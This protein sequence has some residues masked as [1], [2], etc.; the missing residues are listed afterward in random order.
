MPIT[1]EDLE[2]KNF[3]IN[4]KG[5]ELDSKPLRL[6][7]ALMAA[8]L[9]NIFQNPDK[10][11]KEQIKQAET[12]LDELI[13]ELIPEL[14]NKKLGMST[15]LELLTQLMEHIEPADN[16]ELREKNVKFDTDPKV[17]RTG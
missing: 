17:P 1:I 3:K 8:K 12:D 5:L 7:H 11:T 9:G 6:S 2:P 4:L 13:G 16:K 10:V 14:S 15:T